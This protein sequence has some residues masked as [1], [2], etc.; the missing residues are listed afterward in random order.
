MVSD[1][2]LRAIRVEGDL[3]RLV[4]ETWHQSPTFRRQ[5]AT[6][7]SEG[8]PFITLGHCLGRCPN[9]ARAQSVLTSEGGL[10]RQVE[11][12]VK[13]LDTQGLVEV[14]AHEF[15]HILERLDGVDLPRVAA[16]EGHARHGVRRTVDGFYETQRARRAGLVVASEFAAHAG[17]RFSCRSVQG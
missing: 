4:H 16:G 17:A 6:I 11:I 13:P 10:L 2:S 5:L 1:Q 3:A 12:R 8:T 7:V 14:I 9:D 15:E